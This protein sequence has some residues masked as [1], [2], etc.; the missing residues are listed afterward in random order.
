MQRIIIVYNPRSSKH[1]AIRDEVI[2]PASKFKGCLLGKFEVKHVD[3]NENATNLSKILLNG[4]LVV[5]AGGDGTGSV[6]LNG[7]IESGKD[8]TLAIL[9]FGNFND[10]SRTLGYYNITDI[11]TDFIKST[12]SKTANSHIQSLHPLEAIV[13]GKHYRYS[14]CYFTIGMFAESTEVFDQKKTRGTLKS[15]RKSIFYSIKELTKWYFKNKHHHFLPSEIHLNNVPLNHHNTT[16]S[17]RKN[18]IKGTRISDVLFVN[19]KTV[20]KMM[21]GGKYWQS[22]KTFLVSTGRLTNLCHLL[23]FMAKSIF[24]RIPGKCTTESITITFP[25]KEEIEIQGE[26]EYRRLTLSELLIK[27]SDKSIKVLAK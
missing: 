2:T 20:A 10:F 25:T 22:P 23:S 27:K 21:K 9:G 1:A 26:G 7:A 8:V 11:I 13:D 24:R 19:G 14:A 5:A 15:G 18:R 4:D 12:S 3:L 6:A 16:D 17:G